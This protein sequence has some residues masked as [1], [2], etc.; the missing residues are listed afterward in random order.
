MKAAHAK[1]KSQ[2]AKALA[3]LAGHG[4]H[5]ALPHRV[6]PVQAFFMRAANPDT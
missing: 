4:L 1:A 5:R 2:D 6:A 3:L